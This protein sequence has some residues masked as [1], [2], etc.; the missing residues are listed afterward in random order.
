M[1]RATHSFRAP[2]GA[3]AA[4]GRGVSQSRRAVLGAG[5]ACAAAFAARAQS[6]AP[7]AEARDCTRLA[8]AA[9]LDCDAETLRRAAVDFG[10]IVHKRPWAVL[11]P[12]S[13]ADVAAVVRWAGTQGVRVA[14]RGQGHSTYGRSMAEG[15]IVI[16]MS[17]LRTIHRVESDRVVVGAGVA[18]REVLD[19]TVARGLTPP[20]LTNYLGLSV[21]GTLA[22]GGIGGTTSRYG[23][24]TDNVLEL[25]VVTGDG[26][27][28]SCSP[29]GNAELFDAVRGGLGQCAIVVRAHAASGAR[30]GPGTSIP[31]DLSRSRAR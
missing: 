10:G 22:V 29:R 20:V 9:E 15:G 11:E 23:M 6:G 1:H 26:R 30:A 25:D 27:E 5:L 17:A 8:L 24:Q 13:A 7:S 18:W 12:K 31:T 14:A 28:L 3:A 2:H 21:G 19:A 16:D 4:D